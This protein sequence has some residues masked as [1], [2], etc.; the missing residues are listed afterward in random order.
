MN[1]IIEIT[2][3]AGIEEAAAIAAAITAV[4]HEEAERRANPLQAPRQTSW[5]QSWRPREAH[6]PL[7]SHVYDAEPWGVPDETP[8]F[9]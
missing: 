6:S 3:G 4:L 2:G 8:M 9:E 7:P 1:P 5:V